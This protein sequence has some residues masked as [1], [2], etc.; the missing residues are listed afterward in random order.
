MLIVC[1]EVQKKHH[2]PMMSNETIAGCLDD[3]KRAK[4]ACWSIRMME[5]AGYGWMGWGMREGKAVSTRRDRYDNNGIDQQGFHSWFN[6]NGSLRAG[7]DFLRKTPR[8][9][10]PWERL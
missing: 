9:I 3:Q 5:D 1:A 2:K 7:L 6:A 8:Y 4:C 10:A